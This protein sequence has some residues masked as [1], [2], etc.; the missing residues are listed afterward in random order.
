MPQC[1]PTHFRVG[2]LMFTNT[3]LRTFSLT[4]PRSGVL[5]MQTLN[6][7][8]LR[9]QSLKVLPLMPGVRQNIALHVSPTTRDFFLE[10][11][12]TF[13]VH[14]SAFFPKKNIFR[15]FPLLAVVNTGSCVG[16]Q[17]KISHLLVVPDDYAGSRVECPRTINRLHNM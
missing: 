12:S 10:P 2:I 8:L 1:S 7:H 13:S 6:I 15:V 14:L 5:R 4:F 11:I 16:L 17:N 3:N 9:T